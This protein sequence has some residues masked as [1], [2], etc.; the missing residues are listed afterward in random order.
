MPICPKCKQERAK[1][2][3]V[4][5][6]SEFHP[7]DR[8]L[9]CI[10]CLE[11][12]VKADNLQQV[13]KLCRWLDIPF[14]VDQWTR[15]WKNAKEHTLRLY[16]KLIEENPSYNCVDWGEINKK[17]QAAEESQTLEDHVPALNEAWMLKMRQKWPSDQPRT[18]DDYRYLENFYND[19]QSTQSL[20]TA[21]QRDDAKRLAELG[22]I[23]NQKLRAG[24]DAK[25]EMAMYHNI[26][27]AEGFEPKNAKS[28]ADLDSVGELYAWLEKRGW[29]PNW[30]VEPQD[31]VD[32]TMKS[33]QKYLKRLV[34]NDSSIGDQVE[35]RIRQLEFAD[36]MEEDDDLSYGEVSDENEIVYEGAAELDELLGGADNFGDNEGR[37]P[38]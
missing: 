23:V 14:L 16:V 2:E 31:S 5:T 20:I 21:T 1:E 22:L 13:D 34:M 32:F 8:S 36:K 10:P 26:L 28:V 15:I 11:R 27:K 24:I 12:M 38:N 25:N 19:I 37:N 9:I 33:M 17:W 29:K 7:K 3:F 6:S 30:H 35:N 18:A 4:K